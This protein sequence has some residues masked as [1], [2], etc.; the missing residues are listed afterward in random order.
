[1]AIS[2]DQVPS[3]L[4]VPFVTAE[5]NSSRAQQGPALLEYRS[6][7]IGQ[8]TG[9]GTA[10]ANSLHK[11]TNVNQVIALAGRGSQLAR[12]A[13]AYFA[14][15]SFTETY[16]GVLDDDSSAAYA[17][18]TITVSGTA[19]AAGTIYLYVGGKRKTVGVGSGDSASTIATAIATAL[20]IHASG[21][22]TFAS[23]AS[24]DDVTVDGVEF[25][26]TNGAVTPG[27]ATYDYSGSDSDTATSFAAQVNAHATTGES[28]RCIANSDVVTIMAVQGG[29]AG[30]AITLSTDDDITAAVSGAVLSGAGAD[31]DLSIHASADGAVVT[32]YARNAGPQGN[33]CDIRENYQFGEETPAGVTLT[34]VEPTGGT[35]APSLTSLITAMGDT[36]FQVIAHP[37]SDGTSLTSLE[38]EL[39]DRAGPIRMIDGIAIGSAAGS[40]ATL[41]ALGATRN[42]AYSCLVAQPGS[43]PL[44]MPSEFASCVAGVVAYYAAIDPA[45]PLQTLPLSG[46]LAPELSDR[47][48]ISEVNNLLYTG[49]ATTSVGGGDSVQIQRLI[50]TYQT[51]AAGADD[52][53]YLDASTVLTLLYLRYSWRTMIANRCPRHKVANDG[54]RFGSGQA[55]VTPSIIKAE[56]YAWFRQME[57]LGL[58]ES[59]DQFKTDLVVERNISNPN[60]IDVLLSPDLINQLVVT[61]GSIQFIL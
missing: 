18:G 28:V 37:Y 35:T 49:I 21:T 50:T 3:T 33:D 20:G 59:F 56:C 29:T 53:A 60:R 5:F 46:Q 26:A 10:S 19:S 58:V 61:A 42:S 54:T 13:A 11:V 6:L 44:M 16:V 52:T 9:E 7:I 27:D 55:V 4:R 41:A 31:T 22:V 40:Y 24:G 1:M 8:K 15:N 25:V 17:S 39:A 38:T 23:A 48:T 12:M 43:S 36:W 57:E 32:T 34:I 30:N 2:F 14:V 45:R 51:N 47:F